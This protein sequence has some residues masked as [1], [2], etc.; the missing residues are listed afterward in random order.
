MKE[1]EL[2]DEADVAQE[3]VNRLCASKRVVAIAG[4]G[5]STSAGIPV[6]VDCVDGSAAEELTHPIF[7]TTSHLAA[8]TRNGMGAISFNL[9][10]QME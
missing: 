10:R 9:L 1:I 7:R 2:S 5:I 6:S 8:I 4:A 3:L